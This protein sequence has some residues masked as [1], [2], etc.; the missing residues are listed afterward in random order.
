[1]SAW[2]CE[3]KRKRKNQKTA[4]PAIVEVSGKAEVPGNTNVDLP[5]GLVNLLS[6]L[7]FSSSFDA[8]PLRLFY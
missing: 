4:S 1:M 8:S 7:L 3:D 5:S 2:P 6:F